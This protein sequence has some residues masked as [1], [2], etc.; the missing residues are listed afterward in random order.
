MVF[1]SLFY[2]TVNQ[3]RDLDVI[4]RDLLVWRLHG[5]RTGYYD[6]LVPLTVVEGRHKTIAVHRPAPDSIA[7]H[8]PGCKQAAVTLRERT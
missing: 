4:R 2:L 3:A 8:L 7:I 5:R 1:R 6:R